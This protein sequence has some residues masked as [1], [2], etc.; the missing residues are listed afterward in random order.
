[1][2]QIRGRKDFFYGNGLAREF[3][4]SFPAPDAPIGAQYIY[5]IVSNED[6]SD[7]VPVLTNYTL[8]RHGETISLTYP[9]SGDPLAPGKKL[10]VFRKLPLVQPTDLENG[11]T[12]F[13]ETIEYTFDWLEMQIQELKEE[14]DR[15]LKVPLSSDRTP[16]E[17]MAEIL[18]ALEIVRQ[19]KEYLD[20]MEKLLNLEYLE[21][22]VYNVR[23]SFVVQQ[24][25]PAGGTLT[26]PAYYYPTRNVLFLSRQDVPC[27][28][29]PR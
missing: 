24:D 10:T 28:P 18:R 25:I 29:W 14:L 7:S 23:R 1:M 17:V 9:V 6:G 5:M 8:T 3:T 19:A 13:A 2:I 12:F 15:A 27:T 22:G 26:L 16:E 11:D 20:Q 21:S 4:L